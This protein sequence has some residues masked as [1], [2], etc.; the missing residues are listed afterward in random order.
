MAGPSIGNTAA[1]GEGM[2]LNQWKIGPK[3]YLVVGLLAVVAAAIGAL[4]VDAMRTYNE[5]FRLIDR[6]S[7]REILGERVN[8]LIYAV[9][10]DSRGIYMSETLPESEK[11]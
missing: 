11:Y 6:A 3:V 1:P 2:M 7:N 4:G 8:G 10:M 9:V 5:K